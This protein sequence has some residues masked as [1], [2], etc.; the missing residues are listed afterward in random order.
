[1]KG[2][3]SQSAA[4]DAQAGYKGE[5]LRHMFAKERAIAGC[6]VQRLR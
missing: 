5:I 4:D 1:M 6:P 2:F 3:V